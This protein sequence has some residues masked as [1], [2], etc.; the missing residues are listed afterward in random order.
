MSMSIH[1]TLNGHAI[2]ADAVDANTT[3]LAWLRGQGLTGTKE[4]CAEG[5]CGACAVL[6]VRSA[7]AGASR[8]VPV[9][10]CLLLVGAVAGQ[11][12][13]TVEG[14]A[15]GDALHPVQAA[16]ASGGGSQCG[17]CTPG[18]VVSMF[19]EYYRDGR[20]LGEPQL[21]AIAGNLCRCT[22]YRPIRDALVSLG[23]P[24][25]GDAFRER[26][27]DG[28]PA[29]ASVSIEGAGAPFFR[30]SC[31]DELFERLAAHPEARVVAGGTDV[32]VEINQRFERHAA[33]VSVEAVE[34]LLEFRADDDA[35]VI[36]AAMALTD[37][38][39]ELAG[40]VSILD[41]L[42]PLF[43]SR[44]IR[45]RATLGGNI[46]NASPIGDSPPALLA[47]DAELVLAK[48]GGRREVA[49]SE[50]FVGYRQTVLEPGEVIVAIRIPRPL[51]SVARFFK[52]SK[53]V[54]D[55]IS[56][57]AAGFSLRRDDAGVVVA[58]RLAYGGVA[59][60]PARAEEAEALLVGRVFDAHAV[61]A[62]RPALE[63][64]FTPMSDQRGSERYRR[65]M[66]VQLLSK[67]LAEVTP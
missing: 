46:A 59:A 44:L 42:W 6:L 25:E 57:V 16:M 17:Y 61:A 28:A 1:F 10:S 30:P 14:I 55:D 37:V 51:P 26:L 67:L 49:L 11:E 7:E 33:L 32:A 62:A 23:I 35:F 60:T 48:R 12:V 2:T 29:L 47:L 22:G 56:T 8:F 3:L 66:V 41:E 36:G 65:A 34:E 31:L 9:N 20:V 58:A 43:S 24:D 63:A 40:R 19:A 4:G 27:D 18:F 38:E 50:F 53:R 45:N 64:A 52:V 13:L 5:E 21:D 54:H 15:K 39:R